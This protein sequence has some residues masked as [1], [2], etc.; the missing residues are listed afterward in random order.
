[1]IN[2]LELIGALGDLLK[3]LNLPSERVPE[4]EKKR[5]KKLYWGGYVFGV[6]GAGLGVKLVSRLEVSGITNYALWLVAAV[7]GFFL[8]LVIWRRIL[9]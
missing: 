8:C 9:G 1:M 3:L 2:F 6:V 5:R 4:S 7:T